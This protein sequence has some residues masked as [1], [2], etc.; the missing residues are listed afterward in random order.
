MKGPSLPD[1]S[2]YYLSLMIST[3]LYM[4]FTETAQL[5]DLLSSGKYTNLS[6]QHES[7]T[8]WKEIF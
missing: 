2:L 4:L 5:H 6:R 1:T 3:L 7:A 8:C